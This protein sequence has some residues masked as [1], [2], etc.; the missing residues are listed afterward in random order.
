MSN[1][2]KLNVVVVIRNKLPLSFGQNKL[3]DHPFSTYAKLSEKLPNMCVSDGQTGQFFGKFCLRTKWIIPT[4]KSNVLIG[5]HA[6]P[7]TK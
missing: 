1:L 5:R 3:R 7:I 2:N 6:F 4:S